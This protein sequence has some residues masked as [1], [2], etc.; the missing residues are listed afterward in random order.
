VLDE[1]V[2]S[3]RR[4]NCSVSLLPLVAILAPSE[5]DAAED[6]KHIRFDLPAA[7]GG[8]DVFGSTRL[9]LSARLISWFG[10]G[11]PARTKRTSLSKFARPVRPEGTVLPHGRAG[12]ESTQKAIPNAV[13]NDDADNDAH[14]SPCRAQP[15]ASVARAL[16]KVNEINKDPTLTLRTPSART[17]PI[18]LGDVSRSISGQERTADESRLRR[19]APLSVSNTL[20]PN[21]VRSAN[22]SFKRVARRRLRR[23]A[24]CTKAPPSGSLASIGRS[25]AMRKQWWRAPGAS[26][27]CGGGSGLVRLS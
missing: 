17:A 16:R 26:V 2:D 27:L 3:H 4:F 6:V 19:Q 8:I 14:R 23:E 1:S 25:V 24:A 7:I 15:C 21:C 10:S 12:R 20:K 11:A 18:V 13:E 22:F 9:R 5:H